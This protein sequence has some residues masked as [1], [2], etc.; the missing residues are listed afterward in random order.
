M[1]RTTAPEPNELQ[2]WDARLETGVST[3]DLQHRVL[4]D[5]LQGLRAGDA[6]DR[7]PGLAQVLE[8]LKAYADYHFQYEEAWVLQQAG[9]HPQAA[10]HGRLHASFTC[11]LTDL[12]ARLLRGEL[13][14]GDVR[15]FLLRWLIGHIVEQDLPM[16]RA[17]RS[18]VSSAS[19]A[20]FREA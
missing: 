13:G 18:R 2:A 1:N 6:P 10:G 20:L 9:G 15:A 12:E 17:L 7:I 19:G 8:Q 4:F 11:D 16:I 3:I 14:V 5:L